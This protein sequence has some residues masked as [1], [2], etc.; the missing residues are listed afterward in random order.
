[1][2]RSTIFIQSL[3]R[4]YI[5]RPAYLATLRK[6]GWNAVASLTQDGSKYSNYMSSLQ[7]VLQQHGIEFLVNRKFPP[8]TRD[9]SLVR[10]TLTWLE[11]DQV[12]YPLTHP[13]D[14]RPYYI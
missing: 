9:M 13:T 10:T 4:Y 3:Y 5:P 12:A 14:I 8:D 7:D 1:M 6:F 11:Q 2:K